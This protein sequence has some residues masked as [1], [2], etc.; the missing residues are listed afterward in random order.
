MVYNR[1]KTLQSSTTDG[2]GNIIGIYTDGTH[3]TITEGQPTTPDQIANFAK[4]I[5]AGGDTVLQYLPKNVQQQVLSYMGQH[6]M[7]SSKFT[8]TSDGYG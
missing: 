1:M 8:S 5:Q 4:A 6:N 2:N 7:G 3:A